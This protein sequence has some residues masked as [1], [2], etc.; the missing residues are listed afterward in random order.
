MSLRHTL[1]VMV[2]LLNIR[3]SVGMV[4]TAQ[5]RMTHALAKPVAEVKEAVRQARR[6]H[7]DATGWKQNGKRRY[8]FV[9]VTPDVVSFDITEKHNA[10]V[11]NEILGPNFQ[12]VLTSDRSAVYGGI[13]NEQRQICNS[14]TDRDFRKMDEREGE[15][16]ATGVQGAEL[17]HQLFHQWNRFKRGEISRQQLQTECTA[18]EDA[19]KGVLTQGK[20]C[21][22]HPETGDKKKNC[23]HK[24]TQRTCKNLLDVL[25]SLFTFA[26]LE[27]VEPT[28]NAAE[29]QAR[30]LVIKRKLSFGSKSE[31][32]NQFIESI[33]T[34]AATLEKQG[35]HVLTFLVAAMVAAFHGEAEGPSLLPLVGQ[36]SGVPSP[37]VWTM[38]NKIG[39]APTRPPPPRSRIPRHATSKSKSAAA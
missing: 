11:V 20:S 24:K 28:N 21:C 17:E 25:P 29:Q 27:N 4:S 34:A 32:G 18:I 10:D 3:V 22:Q 37:H 7:N 33:M 15:S 36:V 26:R 13:P 30:A 12:G 9:S 16:K 19:M 35:R 1:A 8:A 14:H 2:D 6:V 31:R 23:I 5:K 39:T 38:D